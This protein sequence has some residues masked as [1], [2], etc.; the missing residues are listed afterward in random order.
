[1]DLTLDRIKKLLSFLPTYTR[2]TV[3]IGGTNGKGSTSA[4][5]GSIL[6]VSNIT[7]GRFNSP[8]LVH[9]WDCISLNGAPIT[10][11]YYLETREKVERADADHGV[12]ASSFEIFVDPRSALPKVNTFIASSVSGM[13][14][15][16]SSS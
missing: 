14:A 15:T 10:E 13:L 4:I 12:S 11:S 8:H 6:V 5:V 7:T 9:E 2:P 16:Q 3:H 1:M